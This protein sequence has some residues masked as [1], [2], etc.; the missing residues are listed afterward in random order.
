MDEINYVQELENMIQRI[1]RGEIDIEDVMTDEIMEQYR[2][3]NEVIEN[4]ERTSM[5]SNN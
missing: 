5:G 4:D 3:L 2:K 1:K